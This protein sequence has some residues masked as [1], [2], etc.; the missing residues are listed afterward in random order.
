MIT[1]NNK[2]IIANEL[3]WIRQ[4]FFSRVT[5]LCL[6]EVSVAFNI[7]SSHAN[8]NFKNGHFLQEQFLIFKYLLIL[9]TLPHLQSHT[10]G[11]QIYLFS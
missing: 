9:H 10:L 8:T 4:L 7:S 3:V 6:N 2:P 1:N 5:F 11:F